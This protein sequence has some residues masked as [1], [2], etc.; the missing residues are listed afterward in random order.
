M[1]VSDPR[2]G[3]SA[4]K[5]SK[6]PISVVENMSG[7]IFGSGGGEVCAD[8][9]G[10]EYLGT[11]ELDPNVRRGGDGGI[12]IVVAAPQSIAA[13]QMRALARK[14]AANQRDADGSGSGVADYLNCYFCTQIYRIYTDRAGA[15]MRVNPVNPCTL[16]IRNPRLTIAKWLKIPVPIFF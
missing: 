6:M 5:K 13:E 7:E 15:K 8:L 14:V 12:P 1:A 10:A 2:R 3:A 4:F 11:V 16:F 9:I